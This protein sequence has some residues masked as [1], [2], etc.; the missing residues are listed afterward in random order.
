MS[1]PE[2]LD[3]ACGVC[4]KALPGWGPALMLLLAGKAVVGHVRCMLVGFD[5]VAVGEVIP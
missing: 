2:K 1:R 4:G 5:L 3:Q